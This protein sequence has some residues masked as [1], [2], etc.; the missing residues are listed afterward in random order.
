MNK[1]D[2]IIISRTDPTFNQK[3]QSASTLLSFTGLKAENLFIYH[4][5]LSTINTIL[6]YLYLHL[7]D[8]K[9]PTLLSP[10]LTRAKEKNLLLLNRHMI[11]RMKHLQELKDIYLRKEF[12]KR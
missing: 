12:L 5:L 9:K 1:K 11:T 10:D 3:K 4:S 8:S 2:N 6:N 7:K